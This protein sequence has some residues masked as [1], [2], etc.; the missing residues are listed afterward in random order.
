[1][2]SVTFESLHFSFSERNGAWLGRARSGGSG[3]FV[4]FIG[5]GTIVA[6]VTALISRIINFRSL[7]CFL[8]LISDVLVSIRF[9]HAVAVGRVRSISGLGRFLVI[10]GLG[11]GLGPV[12][13]HI[14]IV[15]PVG[16][17]VRLG[18]SIF[19]VDVGS[20]LLV[21]SVTSVIVPVRLN[22]P[23][24]G[25]P[26][27]GVPSLGAP[28]LVGPALSVSPLDVP[29]LGVRSLLIPPLSVP[30]L[31]VPSLVVPPLIVPSLIVAPILISPCALTNCDPDTI[32]LS[33]TSKYPLEYLDYVDLHQTYC[34]T[35]M[36]T[37]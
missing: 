10:R 31:G 22:I 11:C 6:I 27:L 30:S 12:F 23:H 15:V 21:V 24:L 4:D 29:S 2:A 36:M 9:N 33:P 13:A 35:G 3:N 14:G 1:M 28:S 32:I 8:T 34:A 25:V 19:P 17:P 20:I 16:L 5:F 7:S 37:G 26:S 18:A